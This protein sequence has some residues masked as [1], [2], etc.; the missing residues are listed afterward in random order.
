MS[1]QETLDRL[2][3]KIDAL[4]D[5]DDA[6]PIA[7]EIGRLLE[8]EA[9]SDVCGLLCSLAERLAEFERANSQFGVGA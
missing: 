6:M 4:A 5:P 7:D 8:T 9:D 1:S 2:S 3:A